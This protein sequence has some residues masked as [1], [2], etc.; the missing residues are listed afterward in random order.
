MT[1]TTIHGQPGKL[2]GRQVIRKFISETVDGILCWGYSDGRRV[3]V[4]GE[5]IRSCSFWRAVTL[6]VLPATV[7]TVA[8]VSTTSSS[9]ASF[10]RTGS[11]TA[12]VL[13]SDAGA[14]DLVARR[15]EIPSA[16]RVESRLDRRP[17]Q[18]FVLMIGIGSMPCAHVSG[19]AGITSAG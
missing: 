4:E 19:R 17:H 16:L 18:Y 14:F 3:A 10:Q 7:W 6:S 2:D 8:V 1:P 12:G 5:S 9:G 11:R 13:Y 15:P